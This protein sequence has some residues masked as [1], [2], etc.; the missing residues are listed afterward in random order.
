MVESVECGETEHAAVLLE[1]VQRHQLQNSSCV[2]A[3]ARGTYSLIQIDKP[4][5]PEE[6]QRD[7]VRWQIK[8]LL[9]FPAEQAVIDLFDASGSGSQAMAFAVAAA[10]DKIRYVVDVMRGAGLTIKAIDIPELALRNI[11]ARTNENERGV[12]LISL[13]NDSGLITIVRAGELCMARRIN[14][15]LQ[16]LVA[17]GE[18]EA[19]EGVEISQ[20]QQ[21]ILDGLVLEI[22]RSLDYYESSVSRQSVAAVLLAPL[23][24]ALPGLQSYLDTY[25][26][27]DVRE[28]DL[29]PWLDCSA[30]DLTQQSRCL[31]AIG[32]ALRSDW[33]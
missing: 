4:D 30:V 23:N 28:L 25:L 18:I 32:A 3:L 7:A 27:P 5:V 16:E 11:L 12:A 22:Q 15:G 31:S 26:T 19:V 17:A 33:R 2:A 13:W 9:D 1:M 24:A 20:A 21:D 8:D 14:F 6:E 10:E 29:S